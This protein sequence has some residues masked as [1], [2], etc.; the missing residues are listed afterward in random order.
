MIEPVVPARGAHDAA[1]ALEFREALQH[2]DNRLAQY[3]G[4]QFRVEFRSLHRRGIEHGA[5]LAI[6]I[7]QPR[8]DQIANFRWHRDLL[9]TAYGRYD[10]QGK[11]RVS[12][13]LARHVGADPFR[14]AR[15]VDGGLD[16]LVDLLRRQSWQR[17]APELIGPH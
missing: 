4:E 3:A 8:G 16:Q 9:C 13:R 10:R 5:V 15:V 1:A 11:Q 2:A 17:D 12:I 6:E 14:F 7:G